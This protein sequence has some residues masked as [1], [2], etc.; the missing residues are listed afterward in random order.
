LGLLRGE[1]KRELALLAKRSLPGR[2]LDGGPCGPQAARWLRLPGVD[3][4]QRILEEG[5][6]RQIDAAAADLDSMRLGS[7]EILERK[8]GGADPAARKPPVLEN[9]LERAGRARGRQ[10]RAEFLRGFRLKRDDPGGG[11]VA[12]QRDGRFFRGDEARAQAD[13]DVGTA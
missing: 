7:G 2:N 4:E 5:M 1:C 11:A 10:G 12:E 6:R 9:R 13:F 3:R 8:R